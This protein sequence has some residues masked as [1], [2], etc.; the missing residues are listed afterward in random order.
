MLPQK[1]EEDVKSLLANYYE[2]KKEIPSLVGEDE[3]SKMTL[4]K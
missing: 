1:I 3:K 4:E 2:S